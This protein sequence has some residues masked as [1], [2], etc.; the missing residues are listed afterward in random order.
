MYLCMCVS[1]SYVPIYN[2]GNLLFVHAWASLS[3]VPVI[4]IIMGICKA[5][6]LR[7]KALNKHSITHIMCIEMEMLLAIKMYIRKKKKKKKEE[8]KKANS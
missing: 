4:L 2:N 7:V 1:L 3:Y 8:M 6:T 5:P